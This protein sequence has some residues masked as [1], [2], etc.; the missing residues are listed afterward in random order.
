MRILSFENFSLRRS[1]SSIS[2]ILRFTSRLGVR[3]RFFTSCWVM[4]EPPCSIFPDVTLV[5]K[6]RN[7]AP[8]SMPSL[9]QKVRS[10]VAITASMTRFGTSLIDLT[11][12]RTW[13]PSVPIG[14]PSAQ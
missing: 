1:E 6:A 10:S 2:L 14:V 3:M 13:S 8:R 4:V 9:V 7:T 12:S 5:R 11:G